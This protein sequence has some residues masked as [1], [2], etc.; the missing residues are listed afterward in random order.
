MLWREHDRFAYSL[1]VEGLITPVSD[2]EIV[3]HL[4]GLLCGRVLETDQGKTHVSMQLRNI[5]REYRGIADLQTQGAMQLPFVVTFDG[6]IPTS[7]YFSEGLDE[8]VQSE[9]SEIVRTF[10]VSLPSKSVNNWRA[11]ETHEDGQF[12]ARYEIDADGI[13]TK[14]KLVYLTLG[15]AAKD[16]SVDKIHVVKSLAI[17]KP[18]KM[19]SWWRSVYYTKKTLSTKRC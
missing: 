9:I 19:K 5:S 11:I 13:F 18:A 7:I 1:D 6:G 14:S 16:L 17:F 3:Y 12:S 4:D 10:Q 2:N 15:L 8:K